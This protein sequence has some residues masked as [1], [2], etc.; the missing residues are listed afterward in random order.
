MV[1]KSKLTVTVEVDHEEGTITVKRNGVKCPI[2]KCF[3]VNAQA[4]A[5]CYRDAASYFL[6]IAADEL[7]RYGCDTTLEDQTTLML[8]EHRNVFGDE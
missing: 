5:G 4:L 2:S 8:E 1:N 3:T 6:D 7:N